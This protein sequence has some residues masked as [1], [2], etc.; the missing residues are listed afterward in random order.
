M[1]RSVIVS[2]TANFNAND[3]LSIPFAVCTPI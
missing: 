3:G 1:A 2:S